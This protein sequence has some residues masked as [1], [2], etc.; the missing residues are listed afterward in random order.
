MFLLAVKIMPGAKKVRVKLNRRWH[1]STTPNTTKKICTLFKLI[2]PSNM[3]T[4]RP[5]LPCEEKSKFKPDEKFSL[6][7]KMEIPKVLTLC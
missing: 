7:L 2:Q 3:V 6:L 5:E 4:L 1:I